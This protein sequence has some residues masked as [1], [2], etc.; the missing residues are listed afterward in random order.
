MAERTGLPAVLDQLGATDEPPVPEATQFELA[1]FLG[2]PEAK[3]ER[4]QPT[5]G[6]GRPPGARNRRTLAW[7]EYLLARYR[8]PLEGLVAVSDMPVAELANRLGCTVLEAAI[9]QRLCRIAALPYLHQRTPVSVELERRE[10]IRMV[11]HEGAPEAEAA[12]LEADLADGVPL[13][14]RILETEQYQEVSDDDPA[15]V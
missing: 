8:S 13:A 7:A 14:A 9:E 6:P 4:Y 15:P 3:T 1:A 12:A 10:I 2:L 11:I 5:R